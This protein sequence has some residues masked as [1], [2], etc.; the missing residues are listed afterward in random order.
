MFPAGMKLDAGMK[1]TTVLLVL[2]ATA[3]NRAQAEEVRFVLLICEGLSL[4]IGL[5]LYGFSQW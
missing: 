1:I 3:T 5:R 2:L 4:C